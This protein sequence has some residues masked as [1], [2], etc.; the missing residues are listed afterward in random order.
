[1]IDRCYVVISS[2]E[3]N[4]FRAI[5]QC[6]IDGL[7]KINIFMGRN[8][9]GKSS[10]LEALYLASAAFNMLDPLSRKQNKIGYLLNRRCDRN[11]SWDRG[12]Q[13]LWHRYETE[14]PIEIT[15][16][17]KKHRKL[18]I[19]LTDSHVHPLIRIPFTSN[20]QRFFLSK[21]GMKTMEARRWNRVCFH[22]SILYAQSR[23][24]S[25][26]PH[27]IEK[28]LGEIT[29]DFPET[30]LYLQNM[31]FVDTNLIHQMEKVE[32]SLWN[33]LLKKRL[34]KLVTNVLRKG[35]EV[36][37]EDLTYVPYGDIFQL[38]VK[39]PKT[40]MRADDLGDGARYSMVIL[41]I[42]ALAKATA[43]LIEEPENHQH[44]GGLAKSLEMLL[45]LIKRNNIQLFAST[46]S[47]EFSKMIG[48]IAEEKN[49]ELLTFFIE[50]DKE[51]KIEARKV[52]P[53]DADNLRKMGLDIRF[54]DTI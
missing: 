29:G 36:D 27:D 11:L 53:Q 30:K 2:F 43:I 9:S 28:L 14:Y 46:H 16:K 22:H 39:L 7:S 5:K 32:K 48:K 35:Y 45:D 31:T 15:I 34:D 12:R 37:V 47:I 41:M 24:Q 42:A 52:N 19:V 6:K 21:Y 3:I 40:T 54:L 25:R 1:M 18:K 17:P 23:E 13:A 33:E 49:I 10:I 4:R 51:G 44:P 50:R 20:V 38:A 26:T 8:N